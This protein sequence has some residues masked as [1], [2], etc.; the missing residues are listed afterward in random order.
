M[1]LQQPKSGSAIAAQRRFQNFW[2]SVSSVKM[3][4]T[5][6]EHTVNAIMAALSSVATIEDYKTTG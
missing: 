4:S 6:R 2:S 3:A 5:V 1:P